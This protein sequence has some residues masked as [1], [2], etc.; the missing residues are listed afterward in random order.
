MGATSSVIG[1][2]PRGWADPS[3]KELIDEVESLNNDVNVHHRE[4]LKQ[5]RKNTFKKHELIIKICT[6]KTKRQLDHLTTGDHEM[7]K[8]QLCELVGG[9]EYGKLL[10][11]LSTPEMFLLKH[12]L[13]VACAGIGCDT[14]AIAYILCTSAPEDII[15][16]TKYCSDNGI[17]IAELIVTKTGA[18]RST[19]DGCWPQRLF[20]H[21][22]GPSSRSNDDAE[23]AI[24]EAKALHEVELGSMN[25]F[26][27]ICAT[28]TYDQ[29]DRIDKAL[30]DGAYC[31]MPI[32]LETLIHQKFPKLPINTYLQLWTRRPPAA[33]AFLVEKIAKNPTRM[34]QFFSRYEKPVFVG[35]DKVVRETYHKAGLADFVRKHQSGK[36][37]NAITGWILSNY[38]DRGAEREAEQYTRD[39]TT[40]QGYDLAALLQWDE[41]CAKLRAYFEKGKKELKDYCQGNKIPRAGES[42]PEEDLSE[43]V[44]GPA[45]LKY[46]ESLK[47][48]ALGLEEDE[49]YLE[50][51]A[52]APAPAPAPV[53]AVNEDGTDT[54]DTKMAILIEYLN[55]HFLVVDTE[56]SGYMLDAAFWDRFRELPL[57][58]MGLSPDELSS[59]PDLVE[60]SDGEGVAYGDVLEEIADTLIAAI[61]SEDRGM[62]GK[63]VREIVDEYSIPA[64]QEENPSPTLLEFIHSS[65]NAHSHTDS[66]DELT[67]DEFYAVLEMMNLGLNETDIATIVERSD[68][69]QDSV[70]EWKEAL[71][72]LTDLLHDMC[73]DERD[74]WI[75]LSD[76]QSKKGFWYNVRDQSSNWMS[77][78]ENTWFA[79]S[80]EIQRL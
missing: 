66:K 25:K 55:N 37:A 61:E 14:D 71:P 80:G 76:P 77:D 51:D 16:L 52:S 15:R 2:S 32:T 67:K 39:S 19:K 58:D 79:E 44:S 7:G 8:K 68:H 70:I 48:Q 50:A 72:S 46:S 64:V 49:S 4:L 63:T 28:A 57:G 78:E 12:D 60:W 62:T 69:N 23:T 41:G 33:L 24:A 31:D 1:A 29:L 59:M 34:C 75:G 13:E 5:Q 36:L 21:I 3:L 56:Q 43:Y 73:S 74:H 47:A 27:D 26:I 10:S 20:G 35:V 45:S 40:I 53:P 42:V 65:F 18:P 6:T 38:Q 22:F 11:R 9:K 54:I 17:D 30:Q